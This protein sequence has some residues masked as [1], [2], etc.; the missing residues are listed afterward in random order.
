LPVT[1][2]AFDV[3]L[4]CSGYVYG[5]WLASQLLAG[6]EGRRALLLVGDTLSRAVSPEDMSTAPIFGD[7]GAATLI[8]A[9]NA[10]EA[11][12]VNLGTDG[13]GAAHLCVPAG[14]FRQPSSDKTRTPYSVDSG[15][16]SD[17]DLYM[18]GAE[19][20]SFTLKRVP[21]M[22]SEVLQD[23]GWS[24]GAFIPHQANAFMLKHLA[25]KMK[26]SP[27]QLVLALD[28]YGNTSS[29]SIPLAI[30]AKLGRRLA[31]ESLH[32]VLAGF[33]VGWSWG[34]VAGTFGPMVVPDIVYVED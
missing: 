27:H 32:L 34:A 28:G 17:E 18:D 10:G 13:V 9:D 5:L 7:A 6:R 1:C 19:V 3:N 11:L 30:C 12:S 25:R 24:V 8:I 14:G 2:A 31:S 15:V 23:A 29:A 20:F 4:G 22:V 21:S 26:L 16:R 33:G